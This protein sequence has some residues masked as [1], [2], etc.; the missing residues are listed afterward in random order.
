MNKICD[1][2][3]HSYFSDGTSSPAELVELAS[4][5]GISAL[6][7]T[8]HNT[9]KGL[10]EFMDAGKNSD[11]ITV[12][13][14]EFSTE[15]NK[16]EIHIVGL[17]FQEKYFQEIEDFVELAHMAKLTSNRSLLE[18]LNTAG[19][20]VSEEEVS[21]LTSGAFNRA[22]V[23]MVL[24]NKGYVGSVQEAFDKLLNEN[25]GFYNPPKRITSVAAIRFIKRFGATAIMAHPLLNLT[26]DEML[27][28]L[29]E[30]KEAGLDA[31]ETH[32]T[33]FDEDMTKTALSLAK[34]F[35]LKQSGGSDYHGKAKPGISLGIGR[36]N[37][38]V[39]YS[40]YE[41]MLSCADFNK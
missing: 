7:L 28:F 1:L 15:W 25:K 26:Y 35:D 18:K 6:A 40:C 37:L 19:Y 9:S 20:E 12:A 4:K 29:K 24:V 23:A 11:V 22:H 27:V 5:Q 14:C 21:A 10:K 3:C 13:G 8:D 34:Q 41:D 30:A 36:G 17:F 32:Y 31:I 16:K 39:P 2:H 33:E 38:V